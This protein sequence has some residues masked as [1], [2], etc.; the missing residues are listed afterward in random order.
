MREACRGDHTLAQ[1]GSPTPRYPPAHRRHT[2]VRLLRNQP[3]MHLAP[4]PSRAAALVVSMV[5]AGCSSSNGSPSVLA[6]AAAAD[7]SHGF[8]AAA[9]DAGADDGL[10]Q[11]TATQSCVGYPSNPKW[12]CLESCD[13]AGGCPSGT[14]CHPE[15]GCCTAGGCSAP[16]FSVCVPAA[17]ASSQDPGDA[18]SCPS[19]QSACAATPTFF[20][21]NGNCPPTWTEAQ[22]LATWCPWSALRIIQGC[23]G[24][25][26]VSLG[27]VDTST[28]FFYDPQSGQL[29]GI[30]ETGEVNSSRFLCIGGQPPATSLECADAAVFSGLNP[31]C[32]DG[33]Q[34]GGGD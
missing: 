28:N 12:V 22:K 2:A 3:T 7:R 33:G 15:S 31:S 4:R 21:N 32:G 29:V 25:N 34:D 27:G 14:M 9:L 17:D 20:N 18:A 19:I 13:D 23:N 30:S 26:I 6:D 24:Y 10:P 1:G 11:C 8:S 5:I 16:S